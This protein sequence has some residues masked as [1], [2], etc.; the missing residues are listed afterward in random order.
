M[1]IDMRLENRNDMKLLTENMCVVQ[2]IVD[3]PMEPNNRQM[4]DR[5][6]Y[7]RLVFKKDE[8]IL[9]KAER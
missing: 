8:E 3:L 9:V 6:Q 7:L 2:N 1:I 4:V 5:Y